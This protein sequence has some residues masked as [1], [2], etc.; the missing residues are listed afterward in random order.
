MT[1]MAIG[2]SPSS[3]STFLADLLD[4]TN[5][6]A[7]GPEL[8]LFSL[9]FFYD[10]DKFKYQLNL[11]SRLSSIYLKRNGINYKNLSSFGLDKD[12]FSNLVRSSK[13]LEE[14]LINFAIRF[15][16]LRGKNT[17][18]VVFEKTPQNICCID[19]Y[20]ENTNNHFVHIVRNPVNV[21]KS[22]LNRGFLDNIALLTWF[23]DEAKIYKYLEH[24]RVFIVKYEELIKDPFKIAKDVIETTSGIEV[25]EE[26]IK[27]MYENNEYR[28]YHTFKLDSWSNKSFGVVG[29]EKKK[30]FTENDLNNL[31]TLQNLKVS[32]KYANY[33]NMAEVSFLDIIKK[34]GYINSYYEVIGNRN[35][36]FEF[37]KNEKYKFFRKYVS[38]LKH[39]DAKLSDFP[40]YLNPVEII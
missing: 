15:L 13:N 32:S 6:T 20:L 40:I 38:D 7:V 26:E 37:N 33:F 5:Y 24:T 28:K 21:Y 31:A 4:S 12:K 10:F 2:N 9:E 16:S 19:K 18:G 8:N 1:T 22:L 30:K 36:N 29:K 17:K 27:N 23:L 25:T 3:G 35:K 34:F 39:G 14:F 11:N